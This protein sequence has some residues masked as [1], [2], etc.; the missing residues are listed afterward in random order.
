M[1]AEAFGRDVVA[2][3][4]APVAKGA[5]ARG[6]LVDVNAN[7]EPIDA[8]LPR[9]N[10]PPVAGSLAF[11][12]AMPMEVRPLARKLGLRKQRIGGAMVHVGT[13]GGRRVVATVTGMGT[14]LAT[15]GTKRLLETVNVDRVVVVGITGAV[16]NATPIGTLIV[17]AVVVNSATGAEH[18]P[19]PLGDTAANGKMWTTDVIITAP[20]TLATLRAN[21]VVSLDMETAAVAEVCEARGVPWSVFRV[22]SDRASDGSVD[23]EIFHLS[24]QDGTPN[25]QAVAKYFLRHPGSLPRMAKLAK[26]AKQA[27]ESAA[28]AAIKAC[29]SA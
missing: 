2:R 10:T 5:A 1:A 14:K 12:C 17:P 16:E 13:L 20:D 25:P 18:R 24:N 4:P 9:V 15:E 21:G 29:T 26:G 6:N 11:I 3:G 8:L 28:D 27:T 19:A 7:V 22:I 23:D